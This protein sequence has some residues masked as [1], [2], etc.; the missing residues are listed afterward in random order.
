[1]LSA[2]CIYL[3]IYMYLYLLPY[4][5]LSFINSKC[6]FYLLRLGILYIVLALKVVDSLLP[7][8]CDII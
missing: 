5:Y 8:R 4:A 1:M 7:D 2:N 6:Y 3:K